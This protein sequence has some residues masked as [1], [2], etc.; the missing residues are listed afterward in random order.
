[1]NSHKSKIKKENIVTVIK[2]NIYN[3]ELDL[4]DED[5]EFINEVLNDEDLFWEYPIYKST[6]GLMQWIIQERLER[7]ES[8]DIYYDWYDKENSYE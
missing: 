5:I 8:M 2:N 6:D 1:M 4:Y 3:E 7:S